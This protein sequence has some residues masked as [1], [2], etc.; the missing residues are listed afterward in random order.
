MSVAPFHP[1]RAGPVRG[2]RAGSKLPGSHPLHRA[3]ASVALTLLC[4]L[5]SACAIGTP[6][7]TGPAAPAAA[8]ASSAPTPPAPPSPPPLRPV[9]AEPRAPATQMQPPALGALGVVLAHADRVRTL[10]AGELASE[11]ARLGEA[12][13]GGDATQQMQYALALAQTRNSADLARALSLVQRIANDNTDPP[14][15]LQPLARLLAARYAEQRRV[16]D[17]RERNAQ[18]LRDA[19]RRIEQLNDRLEALRAIERSFGRPASPPPA[20]PAGDGAR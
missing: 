10:P 20:A 11:V 14:V 18:Q 5:L 3:G 17:E 19:Q 8:P 16:E 9:E 1:P 15:A 13:Q 7:T 12:S 6:D 4:A 2:W